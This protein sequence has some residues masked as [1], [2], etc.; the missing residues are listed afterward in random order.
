MF[1][2]RT[3]LKNKIEHGLEHTV[4]L[5]SE[6]ELKNFKENYKLDFSRLKVIIR[7]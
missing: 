7:N 4:D 1:N 2:N 3:Y 6:E 5:S